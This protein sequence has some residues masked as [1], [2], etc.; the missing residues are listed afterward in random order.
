M[1]NEEFEK[2]KARNSAYSLR[3]FARDLGVSK[4]TIGEVINGGRRLSIHNIEIVARKLELTLEVVDALKADL[5]QIPES[6]T[7]KCQD[8]SSYKMPAAAYGPANWKVGGFYT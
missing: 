2:R 4:T 6:Q 5:S 3:A 1:L 7:L 8:G